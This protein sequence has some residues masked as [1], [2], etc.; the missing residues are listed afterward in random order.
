MKRISTSLVSND[1]IFDAQFEARPSNCA[2]H[3]SYALEVLILIIMQIQQK[4]NTFV[5]KQNW[6]KEKKS[7]PC[8]GVMWLGMGKKNIRAEITTK[9]GLSMSRSSNAKRNRVK[10]Y[11]WMANGKHSVS[12]VLPIEDDLHDRIVFFF[13]LKMWFDR[14]WMLGMTLILTPLKCVQ[15]KKKKWKQ[16]C[17]FSRKLWSIC[18]SHKCCSHKRKMKWISLTCQCLV[19][20]VYWIGLW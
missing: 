5:W 11:D 14:D 15:K 10:W 4:V 3:S 1:V 13:L 16:F 2:L 19:S 6:K 18:V 20:I 12:Y 17:K 8:P 7:E 9:Y